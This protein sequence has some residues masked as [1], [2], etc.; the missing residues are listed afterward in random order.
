MAT[1]ACAFVFVCVRA[2]TPARVSA[3]VCVRLPLSVV[4]VC[5]CVLLCACMQAGVFGSVQQGSWKHSYLDAVGF[6]SVDAVS[7]DAVVVDDVVA[8][9]VVA[10]AVVADAVA[11][12]VADAAGGCGACVPCVQHAPL[13]VC[14]C[15]HALWCR[16]QPCSRPGGRSAHKDVIEV[17]QAPEAR[18]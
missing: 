17:K 14:C 9:A 6:V 8:D 2:Y 15:Q 5:V 4:C 16:D 10:D 18:E 12:D 3:F 11:A 7:V 13:L 1:R